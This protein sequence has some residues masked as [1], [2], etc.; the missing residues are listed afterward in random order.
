L[1]GTLKLEGTESAV[2]AEQAKVL[3]PLWEALAGGILQSTA[4]RSAVLRQIE[5]EMSRQQL[6]AIADM[7]LSFNDMRS[8]AEE[9]GAGM[10]LER[11]RDT[12]PGAPAAG[13]PRFSG[14][15]L[16]PEMATRR[17]QF[18]GMSEGQRTA[19]RATAQAGGGFA[20]R[21]GGGAGPRQSLF[22]LRP[23]VELLQVRAQ[24][25]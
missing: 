17:A 20:E 19:F 25:E 22:L 9:Q 18:E 14:G 4:E 3:L 23:L 1:L 24:E 13:Q 10:G 11:N 21:P 2:T 15:D 12:P 6:E 5:G 16:L 7:R 8:W